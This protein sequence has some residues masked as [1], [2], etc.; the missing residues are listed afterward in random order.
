MKERTQKMATEEALKREREKG[1]FQTHYLPM[2]IKVFIFEQ[3]I[4]TWGQSS[5]WLIPKQT[6]K[7]GRTKTGLSPLL[8]NSEQS[9]ER[10]DWALLPAP[11]LSSKF[12]NLSGPQEPHLYN[13]RLKPF[14]FSLLFI[15]ILARHHKYVLV[16]DSKMFG[17]AC[18]WLI[19][20]PFPF[21]NNWQLV[22][23]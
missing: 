2:I 12:L 6:N 16:C 23:L 10:Q 5:N 14:Q 17:V 19:K 1:E 9:A 3:F 21:L 15:R 13:K 22:L 18:K 4:F 11:P 7:S 8:L 20:N